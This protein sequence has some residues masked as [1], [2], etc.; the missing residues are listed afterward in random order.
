MGALLSGAHFIT[1]GMLQ[2]AVEWYVYDYI[3]ASVFVLSFSF[4]IMLEVP[5]SQGIM[6]GKLSYLLFV[7]SS[8]LL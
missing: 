6:L 4:L 7:R 2:A 8:W 3:V 1:D 5:N